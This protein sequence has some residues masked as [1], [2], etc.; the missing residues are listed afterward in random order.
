MI[1]F[2]LHAHFILDRQLKIKHHEFPVAIYK[3]SL[4]LILG[5]MSDHSSSFKMLYIYLH[6][7]KIKCMKLFFLCAPS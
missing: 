2:Y 3:L 4:Y 5:E 1:K 7:R 6:L